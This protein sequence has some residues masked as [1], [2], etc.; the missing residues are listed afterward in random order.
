MKKHKTGRTAIRIL[1]LVLVALILGLGIYNLNAKTLLGEQMPMPFGVGASVV[2]SGS[3]EPEL[4]V[5]DLIIVKET[6]TLRVGQII[7]YQDGNSLVVHRIIAIDGDRITTQGDANTGADE[8]ITAEAVKGEVITAIPV[9]GLAV[10]FLQNPV[11]IVLILGLAIWLLERSFRKEKSED[12]SELDKIKEEIKELS[13][14]L[15]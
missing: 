2:L 15:K 4:S 14:K 9:V 3:M 13:E 1:L 8:P 5:N 12:K 11:V 6:D 7:V 10:H